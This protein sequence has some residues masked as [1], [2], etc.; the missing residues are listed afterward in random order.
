MYFIHILI[1]IF[2]INE[3]YIKS[4]LIYMFLNTFFFLNVP[5]YIWVFL[6]LFVFRLEIEY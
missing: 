5:E 4:A 6:V 1:Y 2:I 3:I